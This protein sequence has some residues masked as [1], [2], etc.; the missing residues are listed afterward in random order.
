MEYA[1]AL[2]RYRSSTIGFTMKFS[3]TRAF[4]LSFVALATVHAY[5]EGPSFYALIDGG[6]AS[7][8]ISGGVAA[9][10]S[11][12]EFITGGVV[13]TFAG[14]KFEK[15]I[16]DLTVGVQLEQGFTLNTPAGSNYYFF[17]NGGELLNRQKNIYVKSSVGSFV[18]GVQPNVAFGTVLMGDPRG[19]S[20]FGSSLAMLDINGSLG[21]VDYASFSYTSPTMAGFTLAGQYVPESRT[22]VGEIKTGSRASA[23]YARGDLTLGLA[24]Y[25]NQIIGKKDLSGNILSANYKLG[26]FT[27]KGITASQ[28]SDTFTSALNTSGIGGS[29]T[30]NDKTSFDAGYYSSKSNISNFKVETAAAGAYYTL[31]KE[32]KLY[33]QYSVVDNK[34]KAT[35]AWNFAG[36]SIITGDLG[37]GQKAKTLNVGLIFSYF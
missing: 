29:Y 12:S 32:L 5:A 1:L 11:K 22:D 17:S 34:G 16:A 28:K 3:R 37:A 2:S 15:T 13:P 31:T 6:M 19:G 10:A 4:L 33:G 36:P 9:S 21:T 30:L 24:T 26:S 8:K 18:M 7:S 14:L 25:T 20:N 27:L 35:S 23:T